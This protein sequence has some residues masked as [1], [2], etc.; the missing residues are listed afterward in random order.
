MQPSAQ[1]FKEQPDAPHWEEE[2]F[3]TED[4][5]AQYPA[6]DEPCYNPDDYA[7]Y[8]DFPQSMLEN[9][10]SHYAQTV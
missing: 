3:E 6:E 8:P 2:T 9:H 7:E 10:V 5:Q 4:Y 1:P